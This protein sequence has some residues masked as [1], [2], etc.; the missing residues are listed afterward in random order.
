MYIEDLS[1]NSLISDAMKLAQFDR[2]TFLALNFISGRNA[3]P[4]SGQSERVTTLPQCTQIYL[5][6]FLYVLSGKENR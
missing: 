3:N 1:D 2:H 5:D 4:N 6:L